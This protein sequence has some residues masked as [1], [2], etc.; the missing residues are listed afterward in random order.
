M[1]LK[2]RGFT[3]TELM[4]S[5]A[6]VGIL[7]AIAQPV[8]VSH[9]AAGYKTEALNLLTRIQVLQEQ[10]FVENRRYA[11]TF[12]QLGLD[13]A[14][15]TESGLYTLSLSNTDVTNYTDFTATATATSAQQSNDGTCKTLSITETGRKSATD[16][17]NQ[18]STED[19]WG[20]TN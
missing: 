1:K 12:G 7:A 18:D 14:L 13:A 10:Y 11:N 3:L 17:S 6:I 5:V 8:F 9:F 20:V 16:I 2:S 15:T 4:I 19:C